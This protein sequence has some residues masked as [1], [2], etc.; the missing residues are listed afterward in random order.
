[1]SKFEYQNQHLKKQ[2]IQKNLFS[3]AP[4]KIKFLEPVATMRYSKVQEQVTK[5]TALLHARKISR[6]GLDFKYTTH[7]GVTT[8][9]IIRVR[10]REQEFECE[11][12]FETS[13][14]LLKFV[15]TREKGSLFFWPKLL[16]L[17]VSKPC[18]DRRIV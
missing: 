11:N 18:G 9:V 8:H 16:V 14:L 12:V 10:L 2:K 15:R 4:H 5:K 7:V 1:M 17:L 3:R 13:N 6:V